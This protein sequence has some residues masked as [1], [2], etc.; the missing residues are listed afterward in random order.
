MPPAITIS[1]DDLDTLT[2]KDLEGVG[3]DTPIWLNLN[4][5][6][7]I[8]ELLADHLV[9]WIDRSDPEKWTEEHF[10]KLKKVVDSRGCEYSLD[11]TALEEKLKNLSNVNARRTSTSPASVLTTSTPTHT[12]TPDPEME[13]ARA[14]RQAEIVRDYNELIEM[15]GRPAFPLEIAQSYTNDF[16][17]HE[18]MVGYWGQAFFG[19][20]DRWISFLNFQLKKRRTMEIFTNYQQAVHDHREKEGIEG[21]IQLLFDEEQQSKVD[22]WKEFHYYR[23]RHLPRMRE[24]A[25]AASKEREQDIIDWEAGKRDPLIPE[26]MGWIHHVRTL[27]ESKLD[28][29]IGLIHWIEAELPKIEQECAESANKGVG[30]ASRSA[31][32]EDEA[33]ESTTLS[34]AHTESAPPSAGK[35]SRRSRRSASGTKI[36]TASLGVIVTPR[37]SSRQGEKLVVPA[38][39]LSHAD[40]GT[41]SLAP[42]DQ[43][44]TSA[45][46]ATREDI[47][48]DPSRKKRSRLENPSTKKSLAE[49]APAKHLSHADLGTASLAPPD[50]SSTSAG[51]ATREDITSDP[52][53]K[54]R[55]R[56]ENPSTKKSPAETAPLRRSQ[57]VIDMASRKIQQQAVEQT[58]GP[59]QIA[60]KT[61]TRREPTAQQV[62]KNPKP[63]PPQSRRQGTTKSRASRKGW[64]PRAAKTTP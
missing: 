3:Y 44:S 53:R 19:Q 42:P 37:V 25:E 8:V 41:A 55:S 29:F 59:S 4:A 1:I 36:S 57:R 58:A 11:A 6:V 24:N 17:E 64:L 14:R 51:R 20:R 54:K 32:K 22:Q 62:K 28:K 43:S 30:D 63:A 39:H 10:K 33:K 21:N 12:P 35:H 27:V 23:H 60:P 26:D 9:R 18:A 56:L 49:T 40:S 15:G 38:K 48:S 52:S 31:E 34:S 13:A 47:T 45:G 61:E 7:L 46:R 5:E 50:Q 16:G 2:A